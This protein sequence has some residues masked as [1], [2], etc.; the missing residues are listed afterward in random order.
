[1]DPLRFAELVEALGV[2]VHTTPTF[3]PSL[4]TTHVR[5]HACDGSERISGAAPPRPFI[6]SAAFSGTRM[7]YMFKAGPQGLGYYLDTA[8]AAP[9][10]APMAVPVP[11]AVSE[12]TAVEPVAPAVPPAAAAAAAAAP[13]APYVPR[14][15]PEDRAGELKVCKSLCLTSARCAGVCIFEERKVCKSL[16]L[17]SASCAGVC[18]FVERKVCKSLFMKGSRCLCLTSS[19]YVPV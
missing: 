18:I 14:K 12:P 7:G 1:M 5:M 6:A 3:S 19:R 13:V 17:T 2:F 10:T 4:L 9:R 11:E 16:C 15:S 8:S